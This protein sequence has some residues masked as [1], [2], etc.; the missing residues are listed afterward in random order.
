MGFKEITADKI[1]ENAI[2]MIRDEWMLISVGNEEK[3]N[4]MTASWGFLGEM[5]GKDCAIAAIRP[6]RHTYGL[7]EENDIFTLCFMGDNREV[8]GICGSKSGR[9][10]DKVKET[11]LTPI[12]QDGT[13]YFNESRLVVICKKLYAADLKPACFIDKAISEKMYNDDYHR[14]YFGE[15]VKVLEKE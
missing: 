3:H 11:G 13:M 2:G 6:T 8:H 12:F 1:K 14:L 5:W 15:V 7:V 4:M 9:D 10:I